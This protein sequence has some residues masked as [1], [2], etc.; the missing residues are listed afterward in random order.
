M[1]AVTQVNR[2]SLSARAQLGTTLCPERKSG[3]RRN[4]TQC[5]AM[6]CQSTLSSCTCTTLI[7]HFNS[8]QNLCRLRQLTNITQTSFSS[9]PHAQSCHASSY[10]HTSCTGSQSEVGRPILPLALVVLQEFLAHDA[11]ELLNLLFCQRFRHQVGTVP[12]RTNFLRAK[13]I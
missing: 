5:P 4:R 6:C 12:I 11:H 3:N 8:Q 7:K 2:E 10:R 9:C 1:S 13:S